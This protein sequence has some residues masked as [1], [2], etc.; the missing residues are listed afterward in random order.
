MSAEW[1]AC[2]TCIARLTIPRD[3]S[4]L[5]TMSTEPAS[6][7]TTVFSGPLTAAIETAPPWGA[8]AS[9]TSVSS[10]KT[11]AMAPVFGSS[12]I[13]RPRFATSASPSSRLKTPATHAATYSPR[14]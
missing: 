7:E 1:K 3:S 13:I 6:P 14:L 8:I 10:A 2:E 9:A 12:C 5:T 11:A 4:P